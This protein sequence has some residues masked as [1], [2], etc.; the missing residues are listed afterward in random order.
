PIS[1]RE[2]TSWASQ[3]ASWH[4]ACS[5]VAD[6]MN[7]STVKAPAGDGEHALQ[8]GSLVSAYRIES[9][10]GTG[11]MGC[12]YRARHA[13]TQRLVALKV[14]REEQLVLERSV[15]RMMREATI[16]ASVSHPG[17]PRLFECGLLDDGRPW[18]A[19][20]LVEGTALAGRMHGGGTL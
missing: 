1:W 8:T 2:R 4:A 10:V 19:M 14:M 5:L 11:G 3:R 13:L 7:G 6:S 20:E 9:L 15:D 17:I 18:I 16:L 12:V